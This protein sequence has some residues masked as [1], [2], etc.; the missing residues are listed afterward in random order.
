MIIRLARIYG[1]YMGSD[2]VAP[3]GLA[4]TQE[5]R[6]ELEIAAAWEAFFGSFSSGEPN[7]SERV[8]EILRAE[9]GR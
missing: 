8:E 4:S 6:D 7:L 5:Q 3:D 1:V 9:L 2:P